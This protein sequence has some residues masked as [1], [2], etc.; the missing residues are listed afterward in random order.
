MSFIAAKEQMN[1]YLNL[2]IEDNDL[3]PEDAPSGTSFCDLEPE[4]GIPCTVKAKVLL[5]GLQF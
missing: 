2:E 3:F 5:K 1:K 4:N